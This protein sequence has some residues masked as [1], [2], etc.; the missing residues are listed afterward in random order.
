MCH[1]IVREPENSIQFVQDTIHIATKLRNRLLKAKVMNMGSKYVSMEHLEALLKNVQKSVH[2]LTKSDVSPQDR[3]NFE[4][5]TKITDDRVLDALQKSIPGSEATVKFLQICRAVTS[6][7]LDLEIS[8]LERVSRMFQSIYFLRMWRNHISC[9]QYFRLKDHFITS[10]AYKCIEI[11]GQSMLTLLN[12]C[13]QNNT[14]D[15]FRLPIF[16]SQTCEQA[17]RLLRS[18]GTVNF[19]K[20]NFSLYE[21]LHM[22]GRVELQHHIAYFKLSEDA[23]SF[24]KNHKRNQKIK[25]Y[26]LP[27]VNEIERVLNEAKQKAIDDG[28]SFGIRSENF[29]EYQFQSRINVDE[30]SDDEDA[31]NMGIEERPNEVDANEGDEESEHTPFTKII[32]EN[33]EEYL[34]RKSSLVWMLTEPS[35]SISKN[36]LRRVQVSNQ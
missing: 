29:E 22:I 28:R 1:Q 31:V 19:T 16:S 32:D 33:G 8:P 34:I 25:I 9:S 15:L 3:Q 30:Y 11:N 6:S 18:M 14:P 5:F 4:S 17:F 36:R 12:I 35:V 27:S 13:R 2:G 24:P 20:I 23:I 10:N 26:E 7:Y 21:I